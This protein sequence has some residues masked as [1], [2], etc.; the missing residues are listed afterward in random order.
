M[1]TAAEHDD[2]VKLCDQLASQTLTKPPA[3]TNQPWHYDDSDWEHEGAKQVQKVVERAWPQG[4]ELYRK[5][6]EAWPASGKHIVASYDDS[7]IVVYQAFCPAIADSA[8]KDQRSV[9]VTTLTA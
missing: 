1:A 8:V 5:Q 4:T 9:S 3:A 7:S 2:V 6:K